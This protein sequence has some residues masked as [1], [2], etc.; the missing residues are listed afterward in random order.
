MRTNS[1]IS[2]CL[3]FI[4]T[5]LVVLEPVS[6]QISP[7]IPN[8]SLKIENAAYYVPP[9]TVD[10]HTEKVAGPNG[11]TVQVQFIDVIIQNTG[12]Y[13][14][15]AVVND[16]LVKLYYSIRYKAHTDDWASASITPNLAPLDSNVTTVKFGLG[17]VNPDPGGWS[18]WLGNLS[19]ASQIDF[20]VMAL[21]G[22][23]TKLTA[24]NPSCWR[25]TSLSV[26]NE[27]GRSGWSNTQ[28][29]TNPSAVH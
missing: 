20:Q 7:P 23:Y 26:F 4:I 3:I 6:T 27:T 24:E 16:T 13:S 28:T 25:I 29:I 11:L 12:P 1:K 2:L 15:Y 19:S 5:S 10:P 9:N 21:S 14:F 18:I 22:F 17:A 8:F